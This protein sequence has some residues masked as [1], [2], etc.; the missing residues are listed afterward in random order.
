MSTLTETKDIPILL[1]STLMI[2]VLG[3]LPTADGADQ[4]DSRVGWG[5]CSLAWGRWGVTEGVSFSHRACLSV[6]G[7]NSGVCQAADGAASG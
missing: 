2:P 3:A 6:G 1:S 5:G 7:Q 4:A